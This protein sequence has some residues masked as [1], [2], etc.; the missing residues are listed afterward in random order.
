MQFITFHLQFSY[1]VLFMTVAIHG[2]IFN[3]SKT[4]DGR[5]GD[6]VFLVELLQFLLIIIGKIMDKME[7]ELYKLIYIN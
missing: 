5:Y 4:A 1:S 6:A 2:T 7:N 3:D